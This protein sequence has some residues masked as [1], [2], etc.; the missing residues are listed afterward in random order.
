MCIGG[1]ILFNIE[2]QLCYFVNWKQIKF[3]NVKITGKKNQDRNCGDGKRIQTNS[4]RKVKK[5][6][7]QLN[8][9]E[10]CLSCNNNRRSII[11]NF[12]SAQCRLP[13]WSINCNQFSIHCLR[14]FS[15]RSKKRQQNPFGKLSAE[16]TL[17]AEALN[18]IKLFNVLS[19]TTWILCVMVENWISANN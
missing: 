19:I 16:N 13:V 14:F 5:I 17:V 15:L 12:V 9:V 2:H 4:E 3:L 18:V 6:Y 11:L 1:C 8:R 10:L 7:I